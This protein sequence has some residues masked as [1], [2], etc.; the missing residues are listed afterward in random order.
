[1][2]HEV[3]GAVLEPESLEFASSCGLVRCGGGR[4]YL[5]GEFLFIDDHPRGAPEAGSAQ[6]TSPQ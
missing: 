3:A 4:G 1:M 5:D 2:D 6:H